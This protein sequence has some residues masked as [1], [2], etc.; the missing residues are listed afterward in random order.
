[1]RRIFPVELR[2]AAGDQRLQLLRGIFQLGGKEALRQEFYVFAERRELVRHLHH[3]A[4]AGLR[5]QIG[6]LLQHLVCGLEI[7]RQL[8]VRVGELFRGQQDVP[9]DLVLGLE[10]MRVAGGRHR[11]AEGPAQRQD[12]AVIVPQGLR[13]GRPAFV[14]Q[15]TVVADRHDFQKIIEGGQAPQLPLAPGADDG[16]EDLAG[17]TGGPD[18]QSLPVL[19]KKA[20]RDDG[21][22]FK[23]LQMGAGNELVKVFQAR[24]VPHQQADVPHPAVLRAGK[25]ADDPRNLGNRARPH[26]LQARDELFQ[27]ARHH[28]GVVGGPVVPE[29]LQAQMGRDEVQ[30]MSG[31]F[32]KQQL[33]QYQRVYVYGVEG[34][35]GPCGRGA[36]E[37]HVELGVVGGQGPVA[38]EVQEGAQRLLLPGRIENVPVPDAGQGGDLFGMGFPGFT[39]VWKVSMIRPPAKSTAPISV[40]R[41]LPASSPVVSRSK[42]TI[43][44]SSGSADSP[45]TASLSSTSFKK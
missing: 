29:S 10:K 33:G 16:V 2:H 36:Q 34:N 19:H 38:G 8:P 5:P 41:S 6:K 22:F 30:L 32:R 23:M 37:T 9:V 21:D 42:A 35:A 3:R 13:I 44:D 7:E 39:K 15:E 14:Q 27:N 40:M 17:L 12:A 4:A 11:L 26:L 31:K 20:L 43:S 24:L 45:C 18:E 28:G 1:V 25:A